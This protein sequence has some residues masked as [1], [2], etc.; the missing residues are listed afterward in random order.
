M[1]NQNSQPIHRVRYGSVSVAIWENQGQNGAFHNATVERSYRDKD[2]KLQSTGSFGL[3]DIAM[4]QLALTEAAQWINERK[5]RAT[6]QDA[7]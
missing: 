1:T 2:E 4:L 6:Q 7:A 3:N 5:A